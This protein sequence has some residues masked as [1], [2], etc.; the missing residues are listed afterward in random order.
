MG[1][2]Q[3]SLEII[4]VKGNTL[5]SKP[6]NNPQEVS[7]LIVTFCP[8][9]HPE[10]TGSPRRIGSRKGIGERNPI[11]LFDGCHG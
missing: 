1:P 7:Q 5:E 9:N 2:L 6:M 4:W 3:K 10:G 8:V 11:R